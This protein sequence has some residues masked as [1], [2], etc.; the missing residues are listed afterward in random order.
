MLY[1]TWYMVH[2][3]W[4]IYIKGCHRKENEWKGNG[5]LTDTFIYVYT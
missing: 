3:V 2:G 5:D 1:G 4:Y